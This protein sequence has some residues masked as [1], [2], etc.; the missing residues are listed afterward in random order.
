MGIGIK[1]SSFGSL[2][3]GVVRTK[4]QTIGMP[5]W[6]RSLLA[7]V[8]IMADITPTAAQSIMAQVELESSD[9]NVNPFQCLASPIDPDLVRPITR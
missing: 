8:P 9:C 7:V 4:I 1:M 3:T 5:S 2:G 6:A